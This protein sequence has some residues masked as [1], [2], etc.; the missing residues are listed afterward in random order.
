[1]HHANIILGNNKKESIVELLAK[2]LSFVVQQN[3]DFLLVETETFGIDEARAL[4]GWAMLKPFVGESKVALISLQSITLEAQ[5]ALLKVFEE[6]T[7]GTYF[8]ISTDS[9]QSF[10]P[11]LLSRVR[12]LRMDQDLALTETKPASE[13]LK[14]L[15]GDL[16]GRLS[17]IKSLQ[18][19]DDK[20]KLKSLIKDLEEVMYRES[21]ANDRL[22]KVLEAKR[23]LAARGSSPRMLLE[24]LAIVL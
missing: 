10:L 1:M 22:I 14:F 15:K 11:T 5:N 3:P 21:G 12:V 24:W 6:P 17:L 4:E 8:F 18:L 7:V 23:L 2:E 16:N 19:K 9:L 20:S 13:A